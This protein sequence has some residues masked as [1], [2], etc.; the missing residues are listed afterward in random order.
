MRYNHIHNE[1]VLSLLVRNA[2]YIHYAIITVFVHVM[3]PQW[4]RPFQWIWPVGP[5]G[6]VRQARQQAQQPQ[7]GRIVCSAHP[8]P[9]FFPEN[10]NPAQGPVFRGKRRTMAAVAG[11]AETYDRVGQS[12]TL[13][14][15]TVLIGC[16]HPL[17]T[18]GGPTA[19]Q[20]GEEATVLAIR[21]L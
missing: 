18:G 2:Q 3:N 5:G 9:L 6:G 12:Q 19:L 11:V 21:Q 4:G 15:I 1:S 16:G 8:P 14:T 20:H 10:K 13:Q 7:A 17:R